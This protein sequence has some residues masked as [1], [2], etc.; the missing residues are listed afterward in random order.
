M[1]KRENKLQKIKLDPIDVAILKSLMN[2]NVKV[3]PSQIADTI[4][5]HPA[6]AKSRILE[7]QERRLVNSFLRGT[8]L[9]VKADR[10]LKNKLRKLLK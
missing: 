4:N 1:A 7:L 9:Y 2:T 8:R 5:I 10:D 3:T 6:T